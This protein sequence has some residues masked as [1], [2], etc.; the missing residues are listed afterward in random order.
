M[1]AY[2]RSPCAAWLRFMKSMSMV[3]HGISAFAWVAKRSR[4]LFS[5]SRPR[6]H[7]FAGLKVCIH[8]MTPSTASSLLAPPAWPV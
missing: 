8:E 4:G 3:D 1:Y 6:I 2:S 5:A 7:I